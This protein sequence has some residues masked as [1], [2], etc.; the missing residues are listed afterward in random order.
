MS[1]IRFTCVT[2]TV[3]GLGYGALWVAGPAWVRSAG[4]DFWNLAEAERDAADAEQVGAE[5]ESVD[6][7]VQ[8]RCAAKEIII[9]DLLA[10]RLTLMEAAAEFRRLHI[11]AP[12]AARSH[13]MV[14]ARSEGERYCRE[15]LQWVRSTMQ[16]WPP[17]QLE[18][19]LARL[20]AELQ[21]H[22]AE[23]DGDVILPAK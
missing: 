16:D 17:T 8:S 2:V 4:L 1:M 21:A 6:R 11:A 12:P 7:I 20:E 10:E 14:P 15:V 18:P 3:L 13:Q 5:I 19:I 22:M 23:H 9:R